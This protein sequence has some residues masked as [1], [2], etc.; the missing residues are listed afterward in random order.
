MWSY[1][2]GVGTLGANAF[3]RTD[4]ERIQLTEKSIATQA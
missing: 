4:V 2:L 3:G 1:P